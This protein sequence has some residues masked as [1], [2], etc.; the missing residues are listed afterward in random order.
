MQRRLKEHK[1]E[2]LGK[3]SDHRLC[4]VWMRGA[5]VSGQR[6]LGETP[7]GTWKRF[8]SCLTYVLARRSLGSPN[9]A[10]VLAWRGV[11]RADAAQH[12][13]E[14]MPGVSGTSRNMCMGGVPEQVLV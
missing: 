10:R 6:L 8:L 13:P 1:N 5:G 3:R 14:P 9:T 12:L 2:R 4:F 7:E 11:G